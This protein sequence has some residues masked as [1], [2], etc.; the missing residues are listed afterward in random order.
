[1]IALCISLPLHLSTPR[2]PESLGRAMYFTGGPSWGSALLPCDSEL[3]PALVL[4]HHASSLE[5]LYSFYPVS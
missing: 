1:M 2:F 5:A 3:C 4:S